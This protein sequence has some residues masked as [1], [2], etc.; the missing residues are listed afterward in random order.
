MPKRP[1]AVFA[2][3]VAMRASM[4]WWPLVVVPIAF[5]SE[6]SETLVELDIEYRHLAETA[7]VPAYERV[8]AVGI[9]PRFIDGLAGMVRRTLEQT[10][11]LCTG[12][13]A[14]QCAVDRTNCPQGRKQ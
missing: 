3:P 5:V 4:V 13:G 14:R 7:G 12:G 11:S 6:H 8:P 9:H 1:K 2:V 10:A